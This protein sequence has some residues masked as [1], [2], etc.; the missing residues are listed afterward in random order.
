MTYK[1][2]QLPPKVSEQEERCVAEVSISVALR[3]PN[4]VQTF[5]YKIHPIEKVTAPPSL[6]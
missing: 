5:N 6:P 2:M 4:V 3:H 1:V